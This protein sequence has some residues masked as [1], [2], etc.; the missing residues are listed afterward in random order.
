MGDSLNA[1]ARAAT[2][3][4]AEDALRDR[5]AAALVGCGP[6]SGAPAVDVLLTSADLAKW[7]GKVEAEFTWVNARFDDR[8]AVVSEAVSAARGVATSCTYQVTDLDVILCQ[9]IEHNSGRTAAFRG[10][11]DAQARA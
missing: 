9:F 1:A 2:S 3:Y 10:D 8:I 7:A 11:G 5:A 6:N 4:E